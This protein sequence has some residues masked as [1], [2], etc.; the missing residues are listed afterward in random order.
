MSEQQGTDRELNLRFDG[1]CSVCHQGIAKGTRAIYVASSG[2][3]HHI[4]CP[5][6]ERGVAGGSAMREY[7]KRKA[8]DDA[9]LESQ[10]ASVRAVFGEG[11]IGKIATFI[12]VDESPR[13][14]TGVWKQGA[15]G[16]ERV[17]ARL[18]ALAEVGVV[19]LH[20]RRIPRTRA[21]IDHLVITPWAVWVIDA[22]RYLQKRPEL[23]VSGGLLSA[24][25]EQLKVGGRDQDKLVDG[26]RWQ[27]ET[28]QSVVGAEAPVF[29]ALCFVEGDWPLIGGSFAV[30]GVQVCWPG[31]LAKTLLRA[32][33]PT[34]DVESVARILASKFPPA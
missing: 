33:Q 16:E 23:V 21:N 15:V 1:T 34:V 8:R 30:R 25:R 24:R 27:V 3:V 9:R 29:G 20:D 12:A 22:K 10:H 28:V 19:S 17:A 26:V 2:S 7:E 18:D 4:S 13:R 31:R 11:L 5:G 14:S 6:M 32:E